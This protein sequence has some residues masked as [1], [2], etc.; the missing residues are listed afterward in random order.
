MSSNEESPNVPSG[1][2]GEWGEVYAFFRILG[3]PTLTQCDENLIERKDGSVRVR[4]IFR[5]PVNRTKN[6]KSK[7]TDKVKIKPLRYVIDENNQLWY[8]ENETRKSVIKID[9]CNE[10]ADLLLK[11]ITSVDADEEIDK[12]REDVYH[13][14]VN[15]LLST[16]IKA[17][18]S[19][20]KDIEL[21]I[22]EK[23]SGS[24]FRSGFSIKS[25]LGQSPSLLNVSGATYFTY[26]I[27]GI[28]IE[29]ANEI[30]GYSV[31]APIYKSLRRGWLSSVVTQ[32]ENR[33]GNL[34]FHSMN[35]TFEANLE[36]IDTKMPEILWNYVL[37]AYSTIPKEDRKNGSKKEKG[38]SHSIA[39]ITEA[40]SKANPVEFS[41]KNKDKLYKYKI[42][43]FLEAVALGM[44]PGSPWSGVED[45]NGGYIIV[46]SNGALVAFLIYDRKLLQTYLFNNTKFDVP[47]IKRINKNRIK[48]GEPPVGRIY[49]KGG[50]LFITLP[51]QIR[52]DL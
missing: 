35:E 30:Q 42:N 29:T 15:K 10:Q 52:F 16:A 31:Q 39:R 36:F 41:E 8:V 14:L 27:S 48:N 37:L 5:A 22:E 21:T 11:Y 44:T 26:E 3:N 47:D 19:E 18:S 24:L 13:F 20:K 51:L 23:L 46:K 33:K 32:I 49:E 40:I 1:N 38:S 2:K 25:L 9:E 4:E 6:K 43:R 17:S 50:S 12:L 45:A 28:T 34:S 7:D